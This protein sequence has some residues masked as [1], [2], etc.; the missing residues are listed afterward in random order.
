MLGWVAKARQF[1]G[2]TIE[3]LH[4]CTWPK[5][6]ELVETTVVVLVAI[7]VL[8]LFVFGIDSVAQFAIRLL[9]GVST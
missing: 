7:G 8:T 3:E 6:N 4:K 9:T 1:V 5:R 2:D